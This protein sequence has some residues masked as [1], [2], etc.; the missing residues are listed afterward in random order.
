MKSFWNIVGRIRAYKL[1][2]GLHI[3][4]N[5]LSVVFSLVSL[6]LIMPFLSLL[7]DK[8][9]L[10][11]I[12]P[13]FALSAK[14]LIDQFNYYLSQI[15]IHY[16]KVEA[17]MWVCVVVAVVFFFKNLFRYAALYF[18]STIR[19]GVVRDLRREVFD[20]MSRLSLG[21][22]TEERKGDLI[23]R[24][25]TDVQEVEQSIMSVLESTFTE[26]IIIGSYLATLFFISPTLTLFV[27]VI[28]PISG[29]V[30]G[31]I[32]K[33]LK[34]KSH[35]A[36]ERLGIILS[37]I[38][39]TLSGMR[40]VKGFNA[41]P[42]QL[43]KFDYHNQLHFE[44]RRAMMRRRELSTPL[45]EVLSIIVV[46]MVLYVGGRMVLANAGD[47]SPE[48]FIG[49]MLIFSQ[50]LNPAKSFSTA[51][52]N[53]QKG[54]AS[55][56]RINQVLDAPITVEESPAA[57]TVEAFQKEI[58]FRN[59]SF[60]YSTGEQVLHNINLNLQKGKVLAL[61]GASGAGK[62]TLADMLPRFYDVTGGSITLDGV[63]IRNYKLHDL[64]ALMGI[65][66]QE[67]ILF[68]DSVFNNIAFGMESTATIE[69]VERA[70]RAA[71]A[72][73]FIM[74]LEHGYETN[75]GDRG[76]KLSGGER[77]RLTIARAILKN[78]PILILD[79]ATS[80]LDSHSEKLVQ[81]ALA[82]LM[83]NRTAIV[84]AHRLL[85]V[86]FADE[87]VVMNR[88]KIIERGTHAE[89]MQQSVGAYR[90]LVEIQFGN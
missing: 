18:M 69:E 25:T 38:D 51:Y 72:H 16:G 78:P 4:F 47:L 27:L 31:R 76:M 45:S 85:T 39:E 34:K 52:Y 6:T 30:I 44:I 12:K 71:H 9:E 13:D 50:I 88:G 11:T 80:S 86:Q 77:Q 22:F 28:L 5:I 59:V 53:I 74:R 70:A 84:I 35:A 46:C 24:V 61:V 54:L 40:V 82:T 41:E 81:A 26:P 2:A 64:R 20:K 14:G 32:G 65:V 1:Q 63:D 66:T 58:V 68:N 56:E 33:T 48:T 37:V 29:F 83:E 55:V 23:T 67:P 3:L 7:F 90:Q 15:I 49:F 75:I 79:E 62:S 19:T 87:I 8:Q 21:Y 36:Q 73:D 42:S 89:L 57:Q 10:V 43:V 60:Q 17:L